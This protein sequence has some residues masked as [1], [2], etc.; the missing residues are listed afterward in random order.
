MQAIATKI[1][2]YIFVYRT[3]HCPAPTRKRVKVGWRA[4]VI[5]DVLGETLTTKIYASKETAI[6]KAR[7]MLYDSGI[8]GFA[9]LYDPDQPETWVFK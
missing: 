5:P 3:G 8:R 1:D 2:Y 9:R 4:E 7:Q 6:G